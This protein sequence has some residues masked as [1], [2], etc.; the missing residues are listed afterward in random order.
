MDLTVAK[1]AEQAQGTDPLAGLRS[2]DRV[3]LQKGLDLFYPANEGLERE[4]DLVQ[5]IEYV[6]SKPEAR[7]DYY[8][9]QYEWPGPAMADLNARDE[10][11]RFVGF[12]V[13]QR[14]YGAK[15]CPLGT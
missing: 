12:E 9:A 3:R 6:F 1:I 15:I 7:K 2:I 13:T 4:E 14:L 8:Q 11:G 10:A 5:S